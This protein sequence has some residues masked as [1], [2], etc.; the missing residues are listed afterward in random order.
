MIFGQATQRAGAAIARLL[1]QAAEVLEHA[2]DSMLLA[3]GPAR[4]FDRPL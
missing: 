2:S 3:V 4:Q 1:I